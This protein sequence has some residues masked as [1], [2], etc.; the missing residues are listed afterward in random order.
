M[1]EVTRILCACV[2]IG[3][4]PGCGKTLST[5]DYMKYVEKEDNGLKKSIVIDK[6]EY[7]VQ[8]RPI[9]YILNKEKLHDPYFKESERRNMLKETLWF[10]ISFKRTDGSPS[11]MKYDVSGLDDYN[12]RLDY[13]LNKAT[14]DIWMIYNDK[15][16]LYPVAYEFENNYNLA[17]QETMVVGFSAT[18]KGYELKDMQLCYN[19][20]I[21]KNGIVK[22]TFLSSDLNNIP[23]IKD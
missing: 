3:I 12:K 6:W 9:D 17:P 7:D 10:N 18:G 19:D 8:Y 22:A 1:K 23:K 4:M 20:K 16:T 5:S 21:F 13:F 15:D 11:P 2:L 14:K